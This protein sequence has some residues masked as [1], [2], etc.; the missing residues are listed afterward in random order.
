MLSYNEQSGCSSSSAGVEAATEAGHD[1]LSGG[2][3]GSGAPGSG[4]GGG[5]GGPAGFG[6][7]SQ[8]FKK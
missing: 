3:S 1:A 8:D 2:H 6:L 4:G 5:G 7:F